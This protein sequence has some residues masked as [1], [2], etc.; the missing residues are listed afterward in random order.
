MI[1][2]HEVGRLTRLLKGARAANADVRRARNKALARV[3][4]LEADIPALFPAIRDVIA[5]R[6]RQVEVE[7]FTAEHDDQHARGELAAAGATY[8]LNAFMNPDYRAYTPDPFSFWP[9]D[10]KW[11]K[12]TTP[13]RDLVKATALIIAEIERLERADTSPIRVLHVDRGSAPRGWGS[14][15]SKAELFALAERVERASA[16]NRDLDVEIWLA[17]GLGKTDGGPDSERGGFPPLSPGMP[18]NGVS[19]YE[20]FERFPTNLGQIARHWGVPRLTTSLDAALTIIPENAFWRAIGNDGEGPD[21]S[22]FRAEIISGEKLR[23]STAVSISAPLA[24][25]AA[26]LKARA[27]GVE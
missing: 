7:G 24:L 16:G 22:M 3:A 25:C 17:V 13:R 14:T 23:L 9:W 27:E 26:A 1:W 18:V 12:P 6:R 19:A 20:C 8:A 2:S 21:P 15:M 11:L 4:E 10:M 5:E